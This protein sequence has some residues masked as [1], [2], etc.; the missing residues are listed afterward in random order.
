LAHQLLLS[1]SYCGLATKLWPRHWQFAKRQ[2]VGAWFANGGDEPILLDTFRK[3]TVIFRRVNVLARCAWSPESRSPVAAAP[4]RNVELREPAR[5]SVVGS[6]G[7]GCR[8][9]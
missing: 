3:E 2:R 7:V 1:S 8:L 4:R 9:T 6:A 5:S